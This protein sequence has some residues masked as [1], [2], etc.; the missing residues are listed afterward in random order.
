MNRAGA[1]TAAAV[2]VLALAAWIAVRGMEDRNAAT[3]VSASDVERERAT[4]KPS[5]DAEASTQSS[6]SAAPPASVLETQRSLTDGSAVLLGRCVD[7][8]GAP[9]ANAEVSWTPLWSEGELGHPRNWQAVDWGAVQAQTLTARSDA[10]GNFRFEALAPRVGERSSALW[11]TQ[12]GRKSVL[13]VLAPVNAGEGAR[14]VGELALELA[15]SPRFEVVEFDGAPAPDATLEFRG[16]FGFESPATSPDE[17]LAQRIF[18][19]RVELGV[20][21]KF[22]GFALDS[23]CDVRAV[24]GAQRSG[25]WRTPKLGDERRRFVLG[26]TFVARGVV[27]WPETG[28]ERARVF[29]HCNAMNERASDTLAQLAIAENGE[30][31]PVELPLGPGYRIYHFGLFGNAYA[32]DVELD[33][34][35]AGD[36]LFVELL[37][38]PAHTARFRVVDGEDRPIAG[39]RV[40]AIFGAGGKWTRK[41]GFSGPDGIAHIEGCIVGSAYL[42]AQAFGYVMTQVPGVLSDDPTHEPIELVLQRG[43]RIKGRVTHAGKPLEKFE[44]Q[45]W[46]EGP[47]AFKTRSFSDREQGDFELDTAPLG[48]VWIFAASHP[49]GQCDP[50][51]LRVNDAEPAEVALEIGAPMRAR[52]R[53]LDSLTRAPLEGAKVQLWSKWG[54]QLMTQLGAPALSGVDGTFE[55]EGATDERT[56]F[57]VEADGYGMVIQPVKGVTQGGIVTLSDVPLVK[58]IGFAMQLSSPVAEDYTAYTLETFMQDWSPPAQSFDAAGRLDLGQVTAGRIS[59]FLSAANGAALSFNLHPVVGRDH[60]EHMELDSSCTLKVTASGVRVAD[61]PN[62]CEAV[63]TYRSA[64]G[65]EIESLAPRRDDGSWLFPSIPVR[66][67]SLSLVGVGSVLHTQSVTLQDGPNELEVRLDGELTRLRVVTPSG[68]PVP[69]AYVI[70]RSASRSDWFARFFV[71]ADGYASI[72]LG[73]LDDLH[74]VVNSPTHGSGTQIP[75]RMPRGA[76]DAAEIEFDTECELR[77]AFSDAGEPLPWMKLFLFDPQATVELRDFIVDQRGEAK[78]EKL[79][80]GTFRLIVDQP[81]LWRKVT[82]VRVDSRRSAVTVDVRRT[83]AL[84]LELRRPGDVAA[85]GMPIELVSEEFG[86]SVGEWIAAGRVRGAAQG[87]VADAQGRLE[88]R[89]LPR[90]RYRWSCGT[91]SGVLDVPPGAVAREVLRVRE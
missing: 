74:A 5:D 23:S 62:P 42:S 51:L 2:I 21:G 28:V 11:V 20:E 26:D 36:E 39:A 40:G 22:T 76:D 49:L 87:L 60:V 6:A 64:A 17:L 53:V 73:Q 14:D 83:G 88:L 24:R 9:V 56:S 27:R 32:P 68:E 43:G 7:E 63:L 57:A 18:Y 1:W 71:D 3:Q 48:E 77:L 41:S 10:S 4:V 84:E 58:K 44:V 16:T 67:A 82:D 75:V 65:R 81:G 35:A 12:P 54:H 59:C 37:A 78:F 69:A 50:V 55:L 34:P 90:G 66:Q 30:W 46:Q 86:A 15:R 80:R 8:G 13:R 91:A 52:G 70:L 89:D 29:V 47:G 61:L 25:S 33:P 79:A 72:P 31:G 85:A 19:R 38:E 45:Y